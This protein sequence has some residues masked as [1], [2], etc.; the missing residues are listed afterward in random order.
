MRETQS[1]NVNYELME[2]MAQIAREK[3]VDKGIL[4]EMLEAGLL[5]AGRKR[6]GPDADIEVKFDPGSGRVVMRLKRKVVEFADDTGLEID[7]AEAQ[8]TD[9]EIQLGQ[10]MAASRPCAR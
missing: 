3:S 9:P 6:F 7:L 8:A 5:Q 2:A 1:R 10:D 4:I